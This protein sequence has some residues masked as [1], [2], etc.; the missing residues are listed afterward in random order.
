VVPPGYSRSGAGRQLNNLGGFHL[1]RVTELHSYTRMG[2][3]RT[4]LR[5]PAFRRLHSPTDVRPSV[6]QPFYQRR[7]R[8]PAG[9]LMGIHEEQGAI[10]GWI[11]IPVVRENLTGPC[12]GV[13]LRRRG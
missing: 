3:V 9:G 12:A 7:A 11:T 8:Q 1:R 4:R 13:V 5:R 2:W 6:R 10:G